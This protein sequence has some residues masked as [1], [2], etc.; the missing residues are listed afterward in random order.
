MVTALTIRTL[1]GVARAMGVAS[2]RWALPDEGGTSSPMPTDRLWALPGLVDSH[3]HLAADTIEELRTADDDAIDRAVEK[4]AWAQLASGVFLVFDK[5]SKNDRTLRILGEP[6]DRRPELEAAGTILTA[7]GGY[8]PGFGHEVEVADLLSAAGASLGDGATWVKL[9]GDW[10]RKGRGVLVNFAENELADVVALA[11]RA[12]CRVAVHAA[13]PDATSVAVAAGVDSIEHGLFMTDDDLRDLGARGGAWVPTI[14]AMS[15]TRDVL[16]ADSSGGRMFADGLANVRSILHGAPAA[17]V[18]VLAGSD[19]AL[20]HGAIAR[21]A[22]A[23]RDYG[24]EASDA[25]AAVTTAG[26]SY[27]GRSSGFDVGQP[28]NAVFYAENPLEH[29][30]T[31]LEPA[32]VFHRGRVI[33]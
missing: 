11:H 33:G 12:G 24:L 31:L 16:G 25:L 2:G 7:P 27:S 3:A 15:A 5:G 20:P 4:N 18:T 13:G 29:L 21:E 14:V 22:L 28:A 26:M 23:L 19:L 30:E 6:P 32:L 17:G 9:I 10:P 1:D 8:Y